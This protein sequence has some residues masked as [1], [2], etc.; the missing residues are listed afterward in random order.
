[1]GWLDDQ[2]RGGCRHL[3]VGTSLPFL[4]SP[5][6]HHLEAWNEA[7]VNGAWGRLGSRIGEQM[8]RAVDLEHWAAFQNGFAEVAEMALAVAYGQRGPAPETVT[9]LSGDV[10]HSYVSE[11]HRVAPNA[12]AT[13]GLDRINR[14]AHASRRHGRMRR[15]RIVQAVC[16]PIRN[17][18]P[19]AMRF[20]TAF[21]AYG[22]AGPMGM[23]A[24]RSAKVPGPPF[25]WRGLAGPWFDNTL[26]ILEDS[27]RGLRMSWFTGVVEDDHERPRLDEVGSVLVQ[28]GPP[29]EVS[30][31]S[32]WTDR[33]R[34]RPATRS[35]RPR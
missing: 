30:R 4:L 1:M 12:V 29:R 8:R 17:P 31:V 35:R 32:R 5:G 7:L 33:L 22:L 20:G 2:M 21:L 18:L 23:V 3:L 11:V 25:R 6:L 24:A 13:P 27:P 26:A 34:Q 15:S 9:F 14:T 19:R 28:A 10:H 16:S